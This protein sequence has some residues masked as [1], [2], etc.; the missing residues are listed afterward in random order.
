M[1]EL[2]QLARDGADFNI[3]DEN[4]MTPLMKASIKG[5]IELLEFLIKQTSEI[6]FEDKKGHTALYY[7]TKENNLDAVKLLY[8]NGAFVTD[9]IYMIAIHNNFKSIIKFFDVHNRKLLL[10]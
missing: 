4:G 3:V 5:D 1:E 9:F 2:Y 8:E 7:A 6:N 10:F